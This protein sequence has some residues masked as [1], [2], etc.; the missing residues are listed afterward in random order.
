MQSHTIDVFEQQVPTPQDAFEPAKE[1]FHRPAITVSQSNQVRVELQPVSDQPQLFDLTVGFLPPHD[2]QAD[3]LLQEILV[4]IGAEFSYDNIANNTCFLGLSREG[5]LL[6][7]FEVRIVFDASDERRS[8]I[9]NIAKQLEIGISAID[10]IK[11]I[12]FG[13]ESNVGVPSKPG[14]NRCVDG[15]ALKTSK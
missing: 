3:G 8:S 9:E 4:M 13:S 10:D 15:N 14:S 2:D 1:K 7:H 5:A 12:R 6:I 11:T